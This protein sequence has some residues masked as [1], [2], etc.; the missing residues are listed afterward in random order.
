M[1]LDRLTDRMSSAPSLLLAAALFLAPAAGAAPLAG[2]LEDLCSIEGCEAVQWSGNGHY[3]AFI[4]TEST[5]SWSDAQA[6]AQAATIGNYSV[7]HLV[8]IE[9]ADENSFVASNVLPG[10][11]VI[12]MKQQ[13][14]IGGNQPD[15]EVKTKAPTEGWEWITPETW[16][17]SNWLSGE[18]N[19]ENANNSGDERYL[20]MWVHYYLSGIDH[21]GM[22]NDENHVATAQA[23]MLG[24]IVEFEYVPE[25]ASLALFALAGGLLALGRRARRA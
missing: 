1:L 23:P 3:Y 22:W 4:A 5:L 13:V 21:R 25:P 17:Y 11:G 18:P 15:G 2:G 20:A 8:S 16:N 6:L 7:G 24:F 19:D 9:D 12:A 10:A 14:W